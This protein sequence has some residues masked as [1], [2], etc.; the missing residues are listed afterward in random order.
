[1]PPAYIMYDESADPPDDALKAESESDSDGGAATGDERR[2]TMSSTRS[3][4][5][6]SRFAVALAYLGLMGLAGRGTLAAIIHVHEGESIQD[7]I[8]AA[9][10]DDEIIVHPG[11]YCEVRIE[12]QG[13]AIWLHSSDGPQV[14]IIDGEGSDCVIYCHQ[15]EGPDTI[16]E[17]FTITSGHSA[18]GG[19]MYC[20]AGPMLIDCTFSANT[21]TEF[22]GGMY[23]PPGC[24]PMLIDCT[25]SA[26][27]AGSFGGGICNMDGLTLIDCTF[28]AN[29]AYYGG[30][31]C[32]FE[33][34]GHSTI[35]NCMF[36]ENSAA[37]AGA[38]GCIHTHMTVT[39]S[40]FIN[41]R[42][43]YS[44]GAMT[45]SDCSPAIT[46]CAFLGNAA[47]THGGGMANGDG[48]WPDPTTV[49]N[50]IFI[51]NAAGYGGGMGNVET[52]NSM[53]S[54]RVTNCTFSAN[55][56][57]VGAGLF[58]GNSFSTVANCIFWG[59][60]DD[61]I[62]TDDLS[63]P[64]VI[65][66]NVQGGWEGQGNIDADPLF[67]QEPHP[68]P[69]DVWGTEDDDYGDLRLSAGSPCIDAADNTAV[70]PDVLDLDEDGDTD[71]PI[72]F[73]LDG[74][75]RFIDD[76]DT[77]DTGYGEPPV[78]DMGAYEFQ[79]PECPADFDGDG[80]V[81]TAD[82]LFL[83]GAWGTPNGDVDG[84]GDTDT[85]DLLALLA[86]WGECA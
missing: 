82:L 1:V 61:E 73:D 37:S 56:A 15:G 65:Y 64:L 24:S 25:F 8:T 7:A 31:V 2:M 83:L 27:T 71:E 28:S 60:H 55:A 12:L 43:D 13:K 62:A 14:T 79:P 16:L 3:P 74:N 18:T 54:P 26:N 53:T 63:E 81:D 29:S 50:C 68:G 57:D 39:G 76:P 59:D 42:A 11:T 34:G 6:C 80:D 30:A 41:N 22:G 38:M 70:P 45:N 17:G 19:G 40:T 72:P 78:V 84:D 85:A 35:T 21:A 49:T 86:A 51:G 9:T 77:E 23:N 4:R 44:G 5:L 67:V 47:G 48:S 69:D 10:D 46:N 75:P 20:A 36:I 58:N 32:H 33:A 66:C 52:Y